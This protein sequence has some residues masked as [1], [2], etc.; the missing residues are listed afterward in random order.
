LLSRA[1]EEDHKTNSDISLKAE[2]GTVCSG[3][4]DYAKGAAA[5]SPRTLAIPLAEKPI[6][7]K[8]RRQLVLALIHYPW[9][10]LGYSVV[11]MGSRLGYRAMTL[12]APH[13]IEIY[14]RPGEDPMYQA[15]DLAHELG[16]AFDLKYNDE[17]HRRKWRELRGIKPSTPWFGCNACPDYST[18]AGDFAETFAYLLLGPGNYHSQMAPAPRPDQIA[19][20]ASFCKIDHLSEALI[21]PPPQKRTLTA[22]QP[23][24]AEKKAEPEESPQSLNKTASAEESR[25]LT[26]AIAPTKEDAS[27][28][29]SPKELKQG[30]SHT[31]APET[32]FAVETP[33]KQGP[34]LQDGPAN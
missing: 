7:E 31:I 23:A 18:P 19:G 3:T 17:G 2:D 20:L 10:D 15:F 11:F 12:T 14:V 6:L 22:T 5:D 21:V 32:P 27:A 34:E 9:Q 4:P 30:E 13:R 26:K 8:D 25:E 28:I 29:E 16:H 33:K 24:K 1:K